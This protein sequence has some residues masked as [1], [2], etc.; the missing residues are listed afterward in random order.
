MPKVLGEGVLQIS[1]S[2]EMPAEVKDQGRRKVLPKN[3]QEEKL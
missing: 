3:E 2:A 1:L